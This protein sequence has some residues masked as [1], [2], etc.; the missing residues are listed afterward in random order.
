MKLRIP[1]A[2]ELFR[3]RTGKNAKQVNGQWLGGIIHPKSSYESI[4][5]LMSRLKKGLKKSLSFESIAR[6]CRAL[7][8]DPNFLLGWP[9]IH[10]EDYQKMIREKE[11]KRRKREE[12]KKKK[13]A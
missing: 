11:E 10:D 6:A 2:M 13:H 1:E 5:T 3:W 4:A 9:S 8:V 12:R 7:L